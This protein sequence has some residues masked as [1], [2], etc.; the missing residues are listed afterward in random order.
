MN[1]SS[2]QGKFFAKQSAKQLTKSLLSWQIV[3][4]IWQLN[5]TI[6]ACF[7]TTIV[8]IE[9][10]LVYDVPPGEGISMVNPG[11]KAYFSTLHR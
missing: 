4:K 9:M 3:L 10:T 11:F 2:F 8:E 1:L 5:T 7:F 6:I